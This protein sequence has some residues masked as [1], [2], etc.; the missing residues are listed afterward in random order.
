MADKRYANSRAGWAIENLFNF[1]RGN[2][3][4]SDSSLTE[5]VQRIAPV[6]LTNISALY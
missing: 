5:D 1:E 4:L 2:N 6:H 3:R